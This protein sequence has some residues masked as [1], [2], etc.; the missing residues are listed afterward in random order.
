MENFYFYVMSSMRATNHV[1][2]VHLGW[3]HTVG[4]ISGT[5]P[6]CHTVSYISGTAPVCHTVGYISGTAPVCRP[7]RD[8][9]V[10]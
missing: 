10:P 5:A 8:G 1:S 7:K 4:Y 2:Y 9:R 6:V 3:C